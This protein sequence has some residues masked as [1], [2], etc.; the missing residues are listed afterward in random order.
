MTAT[1][2]YLIIVILFVRGV[3]LPGAWD[4]VKF[5]LKPNFSSL[6]SGKVWSAALQQLAFSLTIGSGAL[7]TMSSY[8]KFGNNCF[9]VT[10]P[11]FLILLLQDALI[12]VAGDTLMSM[13]GGVAI[14]SVL[15]YLKL[16]TGKEIDELVESGTSLAFIVYPEAMNMMPAHYVW[17]FFFFMMFLLLGISTETV[18]VQTLA[19]CLSDQFAFFAR[20]KWLPVVGTCSLFF[21]LGLVMC[22]DAGWYWFLLS[23]DF[24]GSIGLTAI[25]A[26]Q[27]IV[28]TVVYGQF[29]FEWR[30]NWRSPRCLT[31]LLKGR[32]LLESRYFEYLFGFRQP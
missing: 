15:G 12:V 28:L 3:T 17:E 10:R 26:L 25:V 30:G 6:A 29:L 5:F 23:D 1:L 20:Y 19:T 32:T 14:F 31:V 11:L 24:T 27:F 21:V 22:T 4:G 8:N 9:K 2:P 13:I 7:I 16:R 18:M